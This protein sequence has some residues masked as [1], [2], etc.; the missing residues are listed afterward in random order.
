MWGYGATESTIAGRGIRSHPPGAGSSRRNPPSA[1]LPST[2]FLPVIESGRTEPLRRPDAGPTAA[3]A[4]C[5]VA[6]HE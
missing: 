6:G 2:Q 3:L 4:Q 5:N 1:N